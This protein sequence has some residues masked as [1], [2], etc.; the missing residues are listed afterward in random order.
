MALAL[1]SGSNGHQDSKA[2]IL[3]SSLLFS[4]ESG[5]HLFSVGAKLKI[6]QANKRAYSQISTATKKIGQPVQTHIL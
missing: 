5:Y 6:T 4:A 1:F 2:S 3:L